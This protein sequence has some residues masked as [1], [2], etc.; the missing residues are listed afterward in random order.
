[1][2]LEIVIVVKMCSYGKLQKG[3]IRRD[4][5]HCKA[6]QCG[7]QKKNDDIKC[8]LNKENNIRSLPFLFFDEKEKCA[9]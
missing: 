2:E 4:K 5:I 6:P 1:M 9:T 7:R 8:N 3:E